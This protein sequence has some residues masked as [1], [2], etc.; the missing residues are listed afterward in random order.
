MEK[1]T[2]LQLSRRER[3]IMEIIYSRGQASVADVKEA[4]ED[5]PGYSAVRA[6]MRLLEDK[7]HLKHKQVGRKYVF[8]P[9]VGPAKARR[10]ALKN[11][12]STFFDGSI[13]QAVASLL[14]LDAKKLSEDDLDQLQKLIDQ[15]REEG[16]KQ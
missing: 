2:H 11:L 8:L 12:L 9:T 10:W 3:Q 13:E 5:P 7:G 14:D 1:N 15:A 4:M 6:M 16:K